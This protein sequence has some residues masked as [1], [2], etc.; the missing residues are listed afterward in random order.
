MWL[1]RRKNV[2][3]RITIK[4]DI[5]VSGMTMLRSRIDMHKISKLT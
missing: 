5:E 2:F 1:N 4:T 3:R